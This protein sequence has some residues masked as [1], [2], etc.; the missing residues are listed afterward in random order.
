MKFQIPVS[1]LLLFFIP[2]MAQKNAAPETRFDLASDSSRTVRQTT[3]KSAQTKL[4]LPDVVIL[5][6][7]RYQR[8]V[9]N[10]VTRAQSPT[11]LQ[12]GSPYDPITQWFTRESEKPQVYA[13]TSR[14]TR[15]IW[16]RLWG[17]TSTRILLNGGY[18]QQYDPSTTFQ[19]NTEMDN[20][21][22]QYTNSQYRTMMISGQGDYRINRSLHT[23]T[24]LTLS[25]DRFGLHRH[26]SH[27][28]ER[29]A[30]KINIS[31]E[32][33]FKP[34]QS[35]EGTAGIGYNGL[36]LQSDTGQT[37]LKTSDAL[38]NLFFDY[39]FH[40]NSLQITASGHHLNERLQTPDTL[41]TQKFN[42]LN[43]ALFYPVSRLISASAGIAYQSAKADSQF[44]Q[45]RFSPYGRF[46]LMISNR[47]G[48]TAMIS[49]G[50]E[51][52]H[53]ITRWQN[54]PYLN[55]DIPI[56]PDKKQLGIKLKSEF[57]ITNGLEF[58]LMF[59]R[60][61]YRTYSV[62]HSDPAFHFPDMIMIRDVRL[63]E[64][65]AGATWQYN[66]WLRFQA[67][68]TT[69][70]ASLNNNP[71]T[72]DELPYRPKF[73]LPLRCTLQLEPGL[74]INLIS[75]ITGE[76]HTGFSGSGSLPAFALL[77]LEA[78]KNIIPQLSAEL[79]IYNILNTSYKTWAPFR[80]P[81]IQIM[82][83]LRAKF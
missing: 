8:R 46:N 24:K 56:I 35:S 73:Y 19:V 11:L 66:D 17:G 32:L 80:E 7:D 23:K 83:G 75:E 14:I 49:S 22:G 78:R 65:S 81:G 42:E 48:L 1:L 34:T 57:M 25:D 37:Q 12:P 55:H 52:H 72:L 26:I 44:N 31:T 63:S 27:K 36:S 39:T 41:H 10:K 62:F 69:Y 50:Y 45:F 29:N 68:F 30:S 18:W 54:N 4:E 58:Y 67:S 38:Y 64:T 3:K 15:R 51:M 5:G 59:K 82:T 76:R 16:G 60:D 21:S 70:S 6:H 53:Y 61:W 33:T 13:D 77:H 20:S 74:W 71:L 79:T 28:A 2:A 40:F 43:L 9:S 47:L